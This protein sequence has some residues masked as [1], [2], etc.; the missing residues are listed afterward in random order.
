MPDYLG[1]PDPARTF[2]R[3]LRYREA[4]LD[5]CRRFR[6]ATPDRAVLEQAVEA[7]DRAAVHFTGDPDYH[8]PPGGGGSV[9]P[10]PRGAA[11]E[12]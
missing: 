3:L 12:R 2:G 9:P 8:L 4:L 11:P 10:R 5:L 1:L 6:P 7:F